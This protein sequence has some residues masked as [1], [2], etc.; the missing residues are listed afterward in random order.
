MPKATPTQKRS[1]ITRAI[2]IAGEVY[3]TMRAIMTL[4][5]LLGEDYREAELDIISKA[6]D[7]NVRVLRILDRLEEIDRELTLED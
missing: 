1:W 5:T 3:G 4:A 6:E 7:I 2:N